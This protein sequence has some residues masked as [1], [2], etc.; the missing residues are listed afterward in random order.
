MRLNGRRVSNHVEDRR[1]MGGGAKVGVGG[2]VYAT[3]HDLLLSRAMLVAICILI[4][5]DFPISTLVAT[6][7]LYISI[8]F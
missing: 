7:S 6:D 2:A 4:S 5:D 8:R 3:W 1:G